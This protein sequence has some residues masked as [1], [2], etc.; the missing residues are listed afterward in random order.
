MKAQNVPHWMTWKSASTPGYGWT[1]LCCNGDSASINDRNQTAQRKPRSW[2]ILTNTDRAKPHDMGCH[3]I[4]SACCEAGLK[5]R[6]EV[7]VPTLATEKLTE[8]RADVDAWEHP[9]PPHIRLTVVDAE[10]LHYS[11]AMRKGQEEAP[12]P[13]QAERTKASKY[14]RAKGGVGV[15]GISVQL[16]ERL[17]P[18]LDALLRK[19]AGY[20]RAISKAAGRDGGRRLQEWRK[21]L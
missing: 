10:A 3:T 13:A 19:L 17:G 8:A 1:S 4:H 20:E 15:T 11:S 18:G 9:G 12:Q 21:L 16:T 14:G 2:P 5:S 7:I 6:R